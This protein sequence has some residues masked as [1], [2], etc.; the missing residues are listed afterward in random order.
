MARTATAPARNGAI[1]QVQTRPPA[2]QKPATGTVEAALADPSVKAQ[3]ELVLPSFL[4]ADRFLRVV[5]TEL[6]KNPKLARCSPASFLRS[7][8][9]AAQLGLEIGVNGG[10]Y[11]VPYKDTCT[12]VPGWKGLVDLVSRAG[13]ATVWTG[14]VFEGDEFDYALGDRPF[15]THRPGDESDP[16]KLTHVYAI[17][18]V[19][20]S[21]FPIIEVWTAAKAWRH[22][23]K[24]NKVGRDHYSYRHPE[25]YARKVPLLQ[26]IKYL[27]SSTELATALDLNDQGEIAPVTVSVTPEVPQT[28]APQLTAEAEPAPAAVAVAATPA[29]AQPETA[30]AEPTPAPISQQQLETIIGAMEKRLGVVGAETFVTEV[31]AVLAIEDLS[32]VPADQFSAVMKSLTDDAA[33]AAWSEGK[34]RQGRQLISAERIQE[35]LNNP[36]GELPLQPE[37]ME[38]FES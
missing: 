8:I 27:P 3:L 24:I 25:M 22:R 37:R 32:Q 6:R 19:A 1:Q 5:Q 31:C 4:S 9:T 7:V 10:G 17:G 14:A 38:E 13:R 23:D 20:G 12:F 34:S 2:I 35:L 16:E 33:V 29:D 28:A 36:S 30:A 15:V 21:D 18:R 26:V 11:L